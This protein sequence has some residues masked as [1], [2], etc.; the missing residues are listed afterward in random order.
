MPIPTSLVQN[1]VNQAYDI[2]QNFME[3]VTYISIQRGN[4]DFASDTYTDVEQTFTTKAPLY[5][6]FKDD[7]HNDLSKINQGMLDE[8]FICLINGKDFVDNGI[9]PKLEDAIEING[10]RYQI[11]KIADVPKRFVYAFTLGLPL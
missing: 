11:D 7:I 9:T 1:A 3:D 8:T 4:Y 6:K 2:L 10:I 5:K